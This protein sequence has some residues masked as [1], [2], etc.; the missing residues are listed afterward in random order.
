MNDEELLRKIKSKAKQHFPEPT[1][2]RRI[3]CA[4]I[5][6]GVHNTCNYTF[7]SPGGVATGRCIVCGWWIVF[8]AP[9]SDLF[10]RTIAVTD[11]DP[12]PIIEKYSRELV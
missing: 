1:K 4:V 9:S 10:P 12:N 8:K 3:I 7:Y 6:L 11:T 2:L 5:T